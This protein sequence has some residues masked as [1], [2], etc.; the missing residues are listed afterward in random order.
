LPKKQATSYILS[1][2][3]QR[4]Y[5]IAVEEF[6]DFTCIVIIDQLIENA[7]GHY[8]FL[9]SFSKFVHSRYTQLPATRKYKTLW[10]FL[11]E[12]V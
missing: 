4:S 11:A 10:S 2:F 7:V 12:T 8:D 6:E 9:Q 1:V 3:N 5:L